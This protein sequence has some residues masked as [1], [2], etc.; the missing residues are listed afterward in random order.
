MSEKSKFWYLKNINIFD[1]MDDSQMKMVE[2]MT[3]MSQMGKHHPIYFPEQSSNNIYFLKE[4][5]VKLS[6]L[7]EDGREMILDI[8]GPGELFGELSVVEQGGRKEIAE[9]LDDA[10]VCSM[11][12][13]DFENMV[14]NNPLL[15]LQLTK[16]MGLRLRR[17][18]EKMSD[19]AFK[20][21]TKR[22]I[23]FLVRYADDFGKIRGGTVHISSFLSHQEIAYLT[24]AS[25]QTVTTVLNELKSKELIDFTRKSLTIHNFKELQALA[26]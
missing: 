15:N 17:F 6:R 12:K 5:H 25:R 14:M 18:E 4:G 2:K 19:L 16:W 21:V 26:R 13:E 10:L 7:H 8:L 3:T 22:I 23:S 9:T 24:A 1:G 20:D 11:S